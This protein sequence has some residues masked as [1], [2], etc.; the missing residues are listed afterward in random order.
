MKKSI[1]PGVCAVAAVIAVGHGSIAQAAPGEQRAEREEMRQEGKE[2]RNSMKGQR[3]EMRQKGKEMRQE[4]KEKYRAMRAEQK[5]DM[6]RM[7]QE[8]KEMRNSLKEQGKQVRMQAKE[9]RAEGREK[10]KEMRQEGKEMRQEMREE[11]KEMRQEMRTKGR[12]MAT[13]KRAER[14]AAQYSRAT[15]KL[16][17]IVKRFAEA[18]IGVAGIDSAINVL[19]EKAAAVATAYAAYEKAQKSEDKEI[20]AVARKALLDARDD[21]R[22]YYKTNIR[23]AIT[24]ALKTVR[25]TKGA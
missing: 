6:Q 17:N 7:R 24:D 5:Q 14:F 16:D 20:L 12:M 3:E 13:Q 4:G 22:N 11:G 1:V 8:G 15:K 23:S 10:A 25:N 9:M 2:M 19:D 18:G 21:F